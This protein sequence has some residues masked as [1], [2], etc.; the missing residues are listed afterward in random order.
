MNVRDGLFL[1]AGALGLGAALI[2]AIGAPRLD[3][4]S[5]P[6]ALV[7]G[8]AIPRAA[9]ARA[10][11]ALAADSRNPVT[12]R[13][14]ADALERL[15]EEEL[16]VQHGV[17]L[18]LVETDIAAR[19]ALVQSVLALALAQEAGHEPDEATLRRFHRENAGYFASPAQFSLTIVFIRAGADAAERAAAARRAL[20]AGAPSEGL[21]DAV[22]IPM[23]R[24]ERSRAEWRTLIGENASKA[25]SDLE[26]GQVTDAIPVQG[27]FYLARLDSFVAAPAPPYE[28]IAGQV[29]T[30][31]ERRE[32]ERAVL[33]YVAR[34]RRAARIERRLAP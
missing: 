30:E 32:G 26:P 9:H 10:V 33:A 18:G 13:R 22:A 28:E 27:G 16:L 29:R 20:G 31:W 4:A 11:A 23:P 5:D 6:V 25:A 3:L 19:R 2:G 14:A 17:S 12:P 8:V 24:G 21:G 7:N 15:I 1:I 34:L